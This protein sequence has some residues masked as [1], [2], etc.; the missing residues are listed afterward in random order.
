MIMK[1]SERGLFDLLISLR[2]SRRLPIQSDDGEAK[3][4]AHAVYGPGVRPYI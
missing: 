2:T 3:G 4:A 1:V